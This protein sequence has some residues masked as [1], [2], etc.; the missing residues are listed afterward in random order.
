MSN[1]S[2]SLEINGH[3][4]TLLL[5]RPEKLNALTPE[6]LEEL[7]GHCRT[8]ENSSN[9]RVVLLKSASAKVFCVGADITRWNALMPLDMWRSWIRRGH[10][11]FDA[12]AEL[13]Q[14]VIALMN[15][16]SYGGGLEL[17]AAADIRICSANAKMALPETGLATVPGW[18]G[19]QRLTRLIGSPMVKEMAFTGEPVDAVRARECG[20]VNRVVEDAALADI[21]LQMAHQIAARAPI[22]VQMAKQIIDAG[23]GIA[24]GRTLEA[25]AGACTATTEDAREGGQAFREKRQ[26]EFKAR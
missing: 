22:A 10:Q 1:G 7:A 4:A 25:L 20:L 17:A 6:M 11:V 9:V 18:S 16:L 24:V 26:P 3:V 12:L 19:S 15:G 2:I 5:N 14:P 21:G 13:P 8:L 23:D